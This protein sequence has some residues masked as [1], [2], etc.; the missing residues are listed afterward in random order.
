MIELV[1]LDFDDTLIDNSILDYR[2]FV[3]ICKRFNCYTPTKTEISF[4]RKKGYLAPDI[5][6]WIHNKSKTKFDKKHF[7]NMRI[8]FLESKHSLDFLKLHPYVKYILSFLKKKKIRVVIATLRKK[9]NIIRLF[10]KKENISSNIDM[11]F[12]VKKKVNTRKLPIAIEQKKKIYAKIIQR[13]NID[14]ERILS[15]GDAKADLIAA[16]KYK[17]R[18]IIFDKKSHRI[19]KTMRIRSFLEIKRFIN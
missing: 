9:E 17:I 13:Y 7:L 11:I 5:V 6:N 2:S 15:V 1:I 4:L 14:M 18:H 19:E 10:L 3:I 8:E 12:N 16:K